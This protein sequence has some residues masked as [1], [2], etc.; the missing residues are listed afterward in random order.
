[1]RDKINQVL[2]EIQR[3][4]QVKIL[5]AAESGSR[6]WGF[7]STDSDYDVR[8]IYVHRPEWYLRLQKQRDVI[9]LPVTPVLDVN[10][11]DIQ[12]MLRLLYR[13]NPTLFEWASSPEVYDTTPYFESIRPVIE[14]YFQAKPGL[15]HY[16]SM[17][18][19]NYRE[20]LKGDIVRG[21]KYFYV[22]RPIL[23]CRW[24]LDHNC[25]PPMLFEH[26][27]EDQ[28]PRE[29]TGNETEVRKAIDELLLWKRDAVESGQVRRISVLNRFIEEQIPLLE[30][31]IAALPS[32]RDCASVGR[33]GET[34]D[35]EDRW[36]RLNGLF[37]RALREV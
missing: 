13:S 8:F 16:L 30:E 3:Q 33:N 22:L 29:K 6:A 20:Y 7:A 28:L 12:K 36:E 34:Q 5:Y 24:I 15:Y 4:H 37:L 1:M 21:K 35:C 23:A 10:G 27:L 31:R 2:D 19:K 26:L 17:A 18:K 25:P 9:E 14:G 11:W 32:R